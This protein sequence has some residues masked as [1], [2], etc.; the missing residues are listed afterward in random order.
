MSR[1]N[2]AFTRR[3]RASRQAGALEA[4]RRRRKGPWRPESQD[5]P[6]PVR[7]A[8]PG[9]E[10]RIDWRNCGGTCRR[11]I[12]RGRKRGPDSEERLRG[13]ENA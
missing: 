13:K 8:Q 11:V 1:E 12:R 4:S 5:N 3:I 2:P 9:R 6:A 10:R 7:R